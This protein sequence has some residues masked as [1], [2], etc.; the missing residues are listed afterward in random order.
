MPGA[1]WRFTVLHTFEGVS[2]LDGCFP[3][4]KLNYGSYNTYIQ[5]YCLW[6]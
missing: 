1:N 4:A 5:N 3:A 2:W 6:I